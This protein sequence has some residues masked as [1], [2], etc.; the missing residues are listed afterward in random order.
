MRTDRIPGLAILKGMAFAIRQVF[1]PNLTVR[2]PEELNDISPRHRGRLILAEGP[3]AHFLFLQGRLHR[4][5]GLP[6]SRVLLPAAAMAR[7]CSSVLGGRGFLWA[8]SCG[9]GWPSSTKLPESGV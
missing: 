1:R 4:Y 9:N 8:R 7:S 3:G 5:E 2:Y 6:D